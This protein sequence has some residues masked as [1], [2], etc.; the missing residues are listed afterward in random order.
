MFHYHNN[1]INLPFH[2]MVI[3]VARS[4]KSFSKRIVLN[5][6]CCY[7]W[8]EIAKY[9]KTYLLKPIFEDLLDR[10]EKHSYICLMVY[11][12]ITCLNYWVESRPNHTRLIWFS[13][14]YL[15]KK[16]KK[17]STV[18]STETNYVEIQWYN[19]SSDSNNK[20]TKNRIPVVWSS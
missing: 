1:A 8:N 6:Q 20:H 14:I 17:K 9:L 2:A 5:F 7:L 13:F 16:K 19:C 12:L 18:N 3:R 10:A 4:T 15:K 11:S